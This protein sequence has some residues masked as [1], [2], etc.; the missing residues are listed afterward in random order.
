METF[1]GRK[2]RRGKFSPG[3]SSTEKKK[4]GKDK[5]FELENAKRRKRQQEPRAEQGKKKEGT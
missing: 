2:E 5:N 4:R 3:S 1:T